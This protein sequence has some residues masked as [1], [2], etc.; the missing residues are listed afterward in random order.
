MGAGGSEAATSA[1]HRTAALALQMRRSVNL[2]SPITGLPLPDMAHC[3]LFAHSPKQSQSRVPCPGEARRLRATLRW[4]AEAWTKLRHA[5]EQRL[6]AAQLSANRLVA[7]PRLTTP[8][9]AP[10]GSVAAALR[11]PGDR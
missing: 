11:Q 7:P 6:A 2:R 1:A 9:A 8:P 3:R 10:P 4:A 5:N